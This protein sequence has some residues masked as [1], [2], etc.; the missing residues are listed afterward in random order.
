MSIFTLASL[1]SPLGRLDE[2]S[3]VS[4]AFTWGRLLQEDDDS[5]GNINSHCP[6]TD[7]YNTIPMETKVLNKKPDP[8][9]DIIHTERILIFCQGWAYKLDTLYGIHGLMWPPS[10][11]KTALG[12]WYF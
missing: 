12:S 2:F 10:K 3:R 5:F 6:Q 7:S 9:R 11:G 8:G 1:F 4:N